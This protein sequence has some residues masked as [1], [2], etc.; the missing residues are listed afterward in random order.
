M[1]IGILDPHPSYAIAIGP[2]VDSD[3]AQGGF[4]TGVVA[5]LGTPAGLAEVGEGEDGDRL[6]VHLA[7]PIGAID[8]GWHGLSNGDVER[9][10]N[11]FA[12]G[13]PTDGA[14]GADQDWS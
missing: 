7:D 14:S 1:P 5:V 6:T 8:D 3:G 4:Q 12:L 11:F 10:V 2:G 13:R 9:R